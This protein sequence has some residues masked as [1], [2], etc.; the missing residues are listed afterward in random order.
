MSSRKFGLAQC[1]LQVANGREQPVDMTDADV[2]ALLREGYVQQAKDDGELSI[3]Q[4]LERSRVIPD[5]AA[6][7]GQ[8]LMARL[9]FASAGA[10]EAEEAVEAAEAAEAG[11]DQDR[12]GGGVEEEEE[13]STDAM[14]VDDSATGCIPCGGGKASGTSG[15]PAAPASFWSA[16]FG[17]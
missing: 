16:C 10:A 3:E 7:Q 15:Q 11:D 1:I 12:Q 14:R 6:V 8:S 9:V 13:K 17:A 2:V 4:I 5:A